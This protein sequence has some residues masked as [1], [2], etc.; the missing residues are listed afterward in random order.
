M[1]LAKGIGSHIGFGGEVTYG[2]K[3]AIDLFYKVVSEN[4]RH[5]K[6]MFVS[7]SLDANWDD[8][9]YYSHGKNEG[10]IVFE[11][12]YTGL[13]LFW[14]A[15]LGTY[16]FA[17]D[18][19]VTDVNQHTFSYV[20]STNV[21]PVGLSIEAIRGIGGTDE[22][23]YLGMFP[24]KATVEFAPGQLMRTTF[25]MVGQ[26]T[27]RA[28]A[29]AHT[30]PADNFVVPN[31]K[32]SLAV[33]GTEI[34]ILS[35]SIEIEVNRATDREHYGESL[36]KEPVIIGRPTGAISLECEFSSEAGADTNAFLE[37]FEDETELATPTIVHT[38]NI[39]EGSTPEKLT[40]TGLKLWVT[41]ATPA[42]TGF[43]VT[44]VTVNGRITE[45][46]FVTMDNKTLQ[47]T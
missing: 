46:F 14:H 21:F 24:T 37:A 2:T 45:G 1:P 32:T 16:V 5:V 36:F 13:E 43:D 30:F 38:G 9:I 40:I 6:E 18:T 31:Q 10:S 27:A 29:T 20:H 19:P 8:N 3:G 28:A 47:V 35:G 23:S 17:A 12:G 25:D 11:Q 44:K 33:G 42:T 7:E 39:I 26:G 22:V 15:I 4:L 41:E 34:T